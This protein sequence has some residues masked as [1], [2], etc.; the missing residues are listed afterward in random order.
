MPIEWSTP[1]VGKAEIPRATPWT[2]VL[3][4]RDTGISVKWQCRSL[5]SSMWESDPAC[6]ARITVLVPDD[7]D[8]LFGELSWFV[9]VDGAEKESGRIVFRVVEDRRKPLRPDAVA[10]APPPAD[11]VQPQVAESRA[12]QDGA[13]TAPAAGPAR[14]I[15]VIR[16]GVPIAGLRSEVHP[17]RTVT[18]GRGSELQIHDL[19]LTKRFETD[20]LEIG[21]SR[22]QAE[23]FCNDEGVF[24]RNVGRHPIKLVDASGFP[25]GDVPFDHRWSVGEMIALPGKLRIVLRES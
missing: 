4:L 14:Y 9:S 15:E 24:I 25:T 10:A 21:L 22:R 18:I 17:G 11:A 16:G 7:L 2:Y 20:E 1:P 5:P 19:D 23:V 6:P 3:P 12:P 8:I 13:P